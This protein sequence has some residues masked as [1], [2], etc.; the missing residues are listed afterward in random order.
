M[1]FGGIE[2]GGTKFVCGV[3]TCPQDLLVVSFPTTSPE[4]TVGR[5]CRF[6]REQVGDALRAVGIAS[7]GPVDLDPESDTYGFITSTPKP[8]WQNYDFA[9]TVRRAL[10]IPVG[11]DTDVN[12]AALAESHWGAA[13]GFAD[14][15]YL[16]VG[17]GIGGGAMVAS[18][19]L[20]GLMHPEMGHIRIPHRRQDPFPG[21]CPFHKDCLEG[22]ASGWAIRERW[23]KSADDLPNDHPAWE[24][25]AHYL[26]LALSNFIC[27]LSPQR[28]IMGG[29]VMERDF[30][31]PMIRYQVQ[32]LLN[33]YVQKRA[34]MD[35]MDEYVVPPQ[36]RRHA[37]VLGAILLAQSAAGEM[38]SRLLSSF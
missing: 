25:E 18:R 23:G 34:L 22:L 24:L 10:E 13:Q 11:F 27:T 30:L 8:G 17:T 36:L 33:G 3:G 19:L 1:T 7:F 20:H 26:G 12:A 35:E 29:G 14:F 16:T 6:F 21:N 2:A 37:G 28:I 5:A 15:I 31:F 9:G 32:S 4:E 38:E